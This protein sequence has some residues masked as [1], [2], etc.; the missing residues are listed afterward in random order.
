M[1]TSPGPLHP[2]PSSPVETNNSTVEP[3]ALTKGEPDVNDRPCAD[4]RDGSPG[5]PSSSTHQAQI[6]DAFSDAVPEGTMHIHR[7]KPLHGLKS[8][9]SSSA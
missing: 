2:V 1:P 8:A 4:L 9:S 7:P 3:E 5:I 6:A